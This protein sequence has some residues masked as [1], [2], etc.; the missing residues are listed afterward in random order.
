[1]EDYFSNFEVAEGKKVNGKMTLGENIGDNGGLNVALLAMHNDATVAKELDGLT[2]DQ[3][4]FLSWAR[5]WASNVRPEYA[6]MLLKMDVHSP[7]AARVNGALPHIDEW[8]TAFNV[9]K[10]DPLFVPKNKR[11][12]V[13]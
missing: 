6:D 3:R 12:R 10:S 2:A 13:W 8:Y 4:F 11:A 1:M 5:I 7:N 9:K